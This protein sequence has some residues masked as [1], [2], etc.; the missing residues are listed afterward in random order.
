VSWCGG[1]PAPEDSATPLR[2]KFR[3]IRC[4]NRS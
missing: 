2:Y 4:C 3:W 1:L